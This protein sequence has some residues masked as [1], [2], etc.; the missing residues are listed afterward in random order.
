MADHK[1]AVTRQSASHIVVRT[2]LPHADRCRI[3][4]LP[5]PVEH[6]AFWKVLADFGV[7]QE[8][9]MDRMGAGP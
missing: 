3:L 4:A 8:R 5:Y 1:M 6:Q 7:T 9:L 2:A